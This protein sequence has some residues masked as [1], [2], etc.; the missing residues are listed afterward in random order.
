MHIHEKNTHKF[1][2]LTAEREYVRFLIGCVFSGRPKGRAWPKLP[3]GNYV[4][5]PFSDFTPRQW[6]LNTQIHTKKILFL[7][8]YLGLLIY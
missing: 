6:F 4:T 3:N 1:D 7:I 2:K 5:G 8:I